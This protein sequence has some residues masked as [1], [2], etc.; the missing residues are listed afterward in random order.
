MKNLFFKKD[1][2]NEQFTKLDKLYTEA[3][4]CLLENV[5]KYGEHRD[6][7]TIVQQKMQIIKAA[8]DS[9]RIPSDEIKR[10]AD[11][12]NMLSHALKDVVNDKDIDPLYKLNYAFTLLGM[13]EI[14]FD[15]DAS[16][17]HVK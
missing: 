17:N 16:I 11:I 9:G 10:E 3:I 2:G 15:N 8:C 1:L 6:I 7:W 14:R 12:S 4:R 5:K 13:K